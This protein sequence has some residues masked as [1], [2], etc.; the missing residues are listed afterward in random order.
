LLRIGSVD[1]ETATADPTRKTFTM[2]DQTLDIDSLIARC[3]GNAQLAM[4]IME[5]Y[6]NESVSDMQK[7]EQAVL[8]GDLRLASQ[9]AHRIKGSAA[10]VGA[11]TTSLAASQVEQFAIGG[12]LDAILDQLQTLRS[13]QADVRSAWEHRAQRSAIEPP[14]VPSHS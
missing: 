5:I 3:M 13:I 12:E 6:A 14:Q 7:L 1:A 11:Q 4:R 8:A 9:V 2:A 10:N